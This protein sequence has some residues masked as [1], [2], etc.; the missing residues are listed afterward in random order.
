[1][2]A[3]R[4]PVL[5]GRA[6]EREAL[7][8]LLENVRGGQSAV[9]V[10]RGEAGVGKT[11]LLHHCARQA[12]GFRVARVAGV[13]S[14][15]E[16]PF[17]GLHQL[18]A[19]M[20]GSLDALPEPQQA[21]LGV[22]LG[23]SSGA[24]P[25]RFMVALAAL[26]LL[27]E[28][29]AERPL[30]CFV[31]DAQWLDAVSGQ[32]LG[33]VA[34][35]L[36]A[37]SVAI[38]FAVREPSEEGE[39]T[40]LPEL[41]LGGLPEKDA[42]ALLATVIPGRLD[43]RVR[44]RLVAETRGN[45]LAILELPR[46]LAA[47]DL[48][49]G[50]GLD[51]AHASPGQIEE[52]F[53]RRLEALPDDARMLLLVAAA[54]PGGEPALLWRAADR[55]GIG[56]EAVTPAVSAGLVRIDD[57]VRFHHPLVRSAV[58]WAASPEERCRAHRALAEAT[59]AG[60]D[61]ERRA[62]HAAQG[63]QGTDEDVAVQLEHS[64]GR[65]RA[66]GGA[67]AA[68][69]FLAR[70]VE[71]TPD[72][73][74]RQDRALAAAQANHQAGT[75]DAA[76]RLLSVAEAG[77]LGRHR[78]GHADLLRAQIAFTMERG[79]KAFPL[80]LKAARQLEPH[81]LPLARDTY[82]EAIDAAMFATPNAVCDGQ[83]T[84]AEA[85]RS[86][87]PAK[88]PLRPAD[89]L[90]DGITTLII[91]GHGSG[92]ARLRPALEAFQGPDLSADEGLRWLWLVN[93][94]SASLWDLESCV[95]LADRHIR[96]ARETG[97]ITTLPLA[98]TGRLAAHVAAGELSAAA[99]MIEEVETVSGAVGVSY[100]PYGALMVAAWRGR[101]AECAT[102]MD[103]AVAETTR[104]GEGGP[105]IVG[106]WATALLHNSLGRYGEALDALA[107]VV[108]HGQRDVGTIG[109]W[110][111]VEY[112]EAAARSGDA[113]RAADAFR[114]LE[115][116]TRP[117]GTDWARGIEARSRAL[118][119]G[120]AEAESHYR[121]ALDRLGRS[122]IRGE[123]ARTHLLYGEW[124]RRRRRQREAREHLR[125]AHD[126][127]TDMG[128]EAFARRAAREL[129]ATGEK[130]RRHTVETTT[131]LTAQEVQIV[132]LVREGLTNPEIGARIFISP[133][134]VEW[135]LRNIFTK[136]GVTSRRQLQ[137]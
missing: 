100:P 53:L 98:L 124:L 105:L 116:R 43:E 95:L 59:D 128:M 115:E 37:E 125:T 77:P 12:S 61:P 60:T 123:L 118:I 127:F 68:A 107:G 96:I 133:R 25:D 9:L 74:R 58:Y 4:P 62:W 8:R 14:E 35:R 117:S 134:T 47:T 36:L 132:R 23:L 40:G 11:A 39:L 22:A 82:L 50:F 19:P 94:V 119:S 99:A 20:L 17:A 92:V 79:D 110:A 7:D 76:L 80:L 72:P 45:A 111:L 103:T 63:T 5:L 90:L 109:V 65:A 34:R 54:E 64:A 83:L 49:G 75:P 130:I 120:D 126:S 129:L 16:L 26:S 15:M 86:G 108:D 31:D 122:T 66:R 18:C 89:L 28:V 67:A 81:D 30:L 48:P 73:A 57:H 88:E 55:L 93:I 38:V 85:A 114:R 121:E 70:A 21:A 137:R 71:L 41:A 78:R 29:A 113:D 52:S 1:M 33:F 106:G 104:R 3:R 2:A 46:A 87:P 91:E 44:D 136:L 13:E 24:A 102:L 97:R 32:I 112:I 84:A 51:G 56:I 27:A 101:E 42:R 10:I 6:S 135:H 69:A 131:T